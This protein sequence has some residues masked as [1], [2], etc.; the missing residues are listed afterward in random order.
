V[1]DVVNDRFMKLG[2]DYFRVSAACTMGE[3]F[4]DMSYRGKVNVSRVKTVGAWVVGELGH[5]PEVDE[6]FTW[7]DL[8]VTV[9]EVEDGRLR[10][11]EVKLA[12]PLLDAVTAHAGA[13]EEADKQ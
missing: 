6:T 10:F 5:V 11:V 4:R 13:G 3:L 8:T 7:R 12:N 2:G 9:T 1:D